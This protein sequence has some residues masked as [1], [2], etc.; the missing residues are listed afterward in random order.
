MRKQRKS[1]IFSLLFENKTKM[2]NKTNTKIFLVGCGRHEH[3]I[4]FF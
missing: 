3:L 2:F 1:E 4:Q